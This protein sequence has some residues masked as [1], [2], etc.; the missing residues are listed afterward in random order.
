MAEQIN[1]TSD[2]D[3]G[4]SLSAEAVAV[5]EFTSDFSPTNGELKYITSK[6]AF[7]WGGLASYIAKQCGGVGRRIDDIEL[8][9]VIYS[10]VYRMVS[11]NVLFYGAEGRGTSFNF[12]HKY[13]DKMFNNLSSSIL[14]SF[15]MLDLKAAD[16]TLLDGSLDIEAYRQLW[17]YLF[18]NFHSNAQI[19]YVELRKLHFVTDPVIETT[20]G[21]AIISLVPFSFVK[22]TRAGELQYRKIQAALW[23]YEWSRTQNDEVEL[24]VTLEAARIAKTIKVGLAAAFHQATKGEGDEPE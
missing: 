19:G 24:N 1:R 13:H 22:K 14:D 20:L 21:L 11:S 7:V 10:S 16:P 8:N 2:F 3:H 12:G 9:S 23:K 17:E 6:D 4:V 18:G 15:G 5:L